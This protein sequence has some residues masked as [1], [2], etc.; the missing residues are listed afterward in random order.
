MSKEIKVRK[1]DR[2]ARQL[3]GLKNEGQVH[4]DCI[5][6]RTPLLVIQQTSISDTPRA[7]VL[8]RVVVKCDFC[9]IG[10]SDVK[11]IAGQFYSGAPNDETIIEPIDSDENAPEADILFRAWGK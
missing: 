2:A 7:K 5:E 3:K 1:I 10:F 4:F 8:T 11:Q 9:N 6:C